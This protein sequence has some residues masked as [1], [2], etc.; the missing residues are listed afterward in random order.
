[1]DSQTQSFLEL[2]AMNDLVQLA[3]DKRAAWLW[4]SDGARILWSN[5]AGAA[6]FSAQTVADIYALTALERS[7]A[8]PHI[9]R[10]AASGLTD[11]FSIDRLRFYRGL[12]VMLLTCQ[13]KRVDLGNGETAALIVCSDK[14]LALTKEPIPAFAHLLRS[15]GATVFLVSDGATEET[16]GGLN[17]TPETVPLPEGQKVLIGDF[18]LND[19]SHDGGML[20]IPA[21]PRIYVLSD[22]PHEEPVEDDAELPVDEGITAGDVAALTVAAAAASTF[23][24][25]EQGEP[26]DD[27]ETESADRDAAPMDDASQHIEETPDIAEAG[28]MPQAATGADAGEPFGEEEVRPVTEGN[29]ATAEEEQQQD[30]DLEDTL[31][32]TD[33]EAEAEAEHEGA[34]SEATE[35]TEA[36]IPA[37]TEA[38]TF[39]AADEGQPDTDGDDALESAMADDATPAEAEQTGDGSEDTFVFQP[40]RRPVR[41]AWK[42]DVDQRFTF[43]SDE[44]AE[45]LGPD[46]TDIVGCTWEEV[47]DEFG[48]DPR[49]NI[50]RALDRRDTWSGKTVA[51]P[52]TGA[53]LRVPVDLAALPAFDRN[54]KFEGYRG[55]GVCRTSDAVQDPSGFI[56]SPVQAPETTAPEEDAAPQEDVDPEADTPEQSVEAEDSHVGAGTGED[57]GPD[58]DLEDNQHDAMEAEATNLEAEAEADAHEGQPVADS[59]QEDPVASPD[60]AVDDATADEDPGVTE[61]ADARNEDASPSPDDIGDTEDPGTADDVEAE[62]PGEPADT[63]TGTDT[64]DIAASLPNPASEERS[65]DIAADAEEAAQNAEDLKPAKPDSLSGKTFLGASAAALVGSLA[66]FKGKKAPTPA[67]ASND[68]DD[69][70]AED[71]SLSEDLKSAA[72]ALDAGLEEDVPSEDLSEPSDTE[73]ADQ[74]QV[75]EETDDGPGGVADPAAED[76]V[77]DTGETE[78]EPAEEDAVFENENET[79]TETG[80]SP[81]EVAASADSE[82]LP[83]E[84]VSVADT[85]A[86][87]DEAQVPEPVGIAGSA[88][89][90]P[91]EIESAVK[92]LAKSYKAPEPRAPDL[93]EEDAGAEASSEAEA[94]SMA[95]APEMDHREEAGLEDDDA[96]SSSKDITA[97]HQDDVQDIP[98]GADTGDDV[99]DA[100]SKPTDDEDDG[101]DQPS[102]DLLPETDEDPALDEEREFFEE[103]AA[104][105]HEERAAE[106]EGSVPEDAEPGRKT[107]EVIPLATARPRVVPVDTSGLSRPERQAFR[108]IAE[109]LGARLEGDLEDFEAPD[110][111]E[112]EIADDLPPEVPEAG[113]IDPSLLDRLPI[114]IAIV[115][116]REVLYANKALLSMLGYTSIA[117]L[118]EAGG[119]EALFIDDTDEFADAVGVDGEVDEAMKMRLADGGVLTVDAHMHSVPWNGTRG[120]M[121]S[122]SKR[123]TKQTPG[124]AAPTSPNFFAEVRSELDNAQDQIAEMDTILETATDGVLVL[125]QHG[126]IV[127]VNGSAEALFS[128]NRADMIGAPFTQY[129]APESNRAAMDYLDGLS[130]NGVASIL[131][132]GR[133]VL[134]QVP[135][136]GLIPL[137]MTMGRI[138]SRDDDPKYCAVLRD[139]TQWKTAEEELTQAKR[140]AENASSQKSDFLAKISHEIRTPLN[141]I[142]GFSEVMMEERFG[143]IGNDRYKDYLKDIRT[144][145]SHIMSLVNDLLDLSKIEAGKLDLKFTAVSTNDV[146]NECVALMQPQANRERV[147]IRASLPDSVPEVVADQRSLRQIVLNLLSNGIKYN[148]SGGQVI[149]STAL[150]SNG[151]VALRVR[152]T[153]TGMTAKQLGAALE[154]FRQL[155]TSSRGGGTGLGL[156]LTKALVEA[157]RASFHIDSTPDQGTLVE[158]IFPT[159]RVLSE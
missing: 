73:M 62:E 5:A 44:F 127:K 85:N 11:R 65:E 22:D 15:N 43:L 92:T 31:D 158:I 20:Q 105:E 7:P 134:G 100:V 118:S 38:D 74:A 144:S 61:T 1:M 51:W 76:E 136:G 84:D 99:E 16:Y 98:S 111:E 135:A 13:C 39:H 143:S 148:K 55:F 48:L 26:A 126:T 28:N 19:Q 123:E 157:N 116:D 41:F 152:D 153:G 124:T 139:I 67:A 47:S 103:T 117:A 83:D 58:E 3:A 70:P 150:E 110:P 35:E 107:G 2:C 130:R 54:R 50:S 59:S 9:A 72:A 145:G 36:D 12:R 56:P 88:P 4:S 129:L 93:F 89:L 60:A 140:Q 112:E 147:I 45:V 113:P 42:M 6:F 131:N 137:F 40:R 138:T 23:A 78:R 146:I 79:E 94:A 10:I 80:H 87:A 109:A 125:D 30:P 142:I 122:I 64:A 86:D 69:I 106:A 91:A 14:G 155:H 71:V 104:F 121:I 95:D 53:A 101:T 96:A 159:Q 37:E 52:V 151:E 25:D 132:D 114:G 66:R 24:A 57:V 133:E 21:G 115:H 154:P 18:E 90:R 34:A 156:P 120:L 29:E 141:A 17:G 46:A 119:L 63:D 49:D 128:A 149:L 81:A 33:A 108:K 8:R 77:P 27:G 68:Q 102:A 82:S 32:E 75:T 97:A